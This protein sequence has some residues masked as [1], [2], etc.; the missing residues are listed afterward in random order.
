MGAQRIRHDLVTER[1]HGLNIVHT[2]KMCILNP[3][4]SFE[5]RIT[6][7]ALCVTPPLK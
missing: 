1:I 7:F 3:D 5:L 2:L 4:L 6:T